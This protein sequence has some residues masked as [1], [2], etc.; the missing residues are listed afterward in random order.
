MKAVYFVYRE[1]FRVD[2][3]VLQERLRTLP[4]KVTHNVMV[5]QAR[6]TSNCLRLLSQGIYPYNFAD[7]IILKC[8][9]NTVFYGRLQ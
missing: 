8:L 9:E 6:N 3:K 1:K 2:Y 5:G 7:I 4:E